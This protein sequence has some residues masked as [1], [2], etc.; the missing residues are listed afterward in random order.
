MG[1]S[2]S[3]FNA[4]THLSSSEGDNAEATRD[5]LNLWK[6]LEKTG[7]RM[8]GGHCS[9]GLNLLMTFWFVLRAGNQ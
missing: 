3:I 7:S 1:C 8:L 5:L 9:D 6:L 2:D 4:I